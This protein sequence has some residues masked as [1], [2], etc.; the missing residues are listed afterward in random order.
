ME[1]AQRD[2]AEKTLKFGL[3]EY[4]VQNEKLTCIYIHKSVLIIDCNWYGFGG[5]QDK[6]DFLTPQAK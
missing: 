1:R 6:F 3:N 2:S 4:S 5:M